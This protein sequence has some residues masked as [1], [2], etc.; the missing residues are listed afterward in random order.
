LLL[1]LLFE[2]LDPIKLKEDTGGE[3]VLG[4]LVDWDCGEKLKLFELLEPIKLKEDMGAEVVVVLFG[5]K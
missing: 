3:Y 4:V 5:L 1:L 2:L